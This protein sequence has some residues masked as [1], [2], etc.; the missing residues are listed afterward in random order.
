MECCQRIVSTWGKGII[1]IDS[2]VPSGPRRLHLVRMYPWMS[3]FVG[4]SNGSWRPCRT[5]CMN[6][7]E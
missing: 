4:T 3:G 2:S 6:C 1:A 5:A 7:R